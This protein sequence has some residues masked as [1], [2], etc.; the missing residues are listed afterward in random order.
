[1]GVVSLVVVV[2]LV[3]FMVKDLKSKLDAPQVYVSNSTGECV[4]VVSPKGEQPCKPGDERKYERVWV[5]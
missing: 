1:M 3:V 4:K 2:V 5:K